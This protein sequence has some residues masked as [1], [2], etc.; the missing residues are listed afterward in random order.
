MIGKKNNASIN[1][2]PMIPAPR[3]RSRV[4]S[5]PVGVMY[6]SKH[7][8]ASNAPASCKG[9]TATGTA[10]E[11]VTPGDAAY[12]SRDDRGAKTAGQAAS[13]GTG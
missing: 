5:F 9:H 1:M 4:G 6:A 8:G 7:G 13:S 12:I 2:T 3:S 10:T 11:R